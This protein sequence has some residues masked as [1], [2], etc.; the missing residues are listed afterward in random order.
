MDDVWGYHQLALRADQTRTAYDKVFIPNHLG[1]R[2]TLTPI[3]PLLQQID[4]EL[5]RAVKVGRLEVPGLD[6][7]IANKEDV[8]YNS[9]YLWV[10]LAPQ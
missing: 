9:S 8:V 4:S 6:E 1:H 7:F 10:W 2:V 3:L 5:R